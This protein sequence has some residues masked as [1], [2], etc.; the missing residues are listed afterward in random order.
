VHLSDDDGVIDGEQEG[1]DPHR[2]GDGRAGS[3]GT[4]SAPT[5]SS[6]SAILPFDGRHPLDRASGAGI[7]EDGVLQRA[8]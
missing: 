6:A 2:H 8:R 4:H 5:L 7:L 3:R 1:Q